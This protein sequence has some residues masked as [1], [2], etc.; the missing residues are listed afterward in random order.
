MKWQ[1]LSFL[2]PLSV[3]NSVQLQAKIDDKSSL[4]VVL[5]LSRLV[6]G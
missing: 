2:R 3:I 6:R 1:L 5:L 4:L